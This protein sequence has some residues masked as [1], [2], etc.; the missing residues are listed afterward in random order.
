M[1]AI[2]AVIVINATEQ[3]RLTWENGTLTREYHHINYS[4][5]SVHENVELKTFIQNLVS[6]CKHAEVRIV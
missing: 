4:R 3:E 2:T 1:E 6:A 5:E